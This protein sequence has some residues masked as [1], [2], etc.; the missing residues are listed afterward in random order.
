MSNMQ[1][2]FVAANPKQSF[3]RWM[4]QL[5][6]KK[7]SSVHL[8]TVPWV[9][10]LFFSLTRG[11]YKQRVLWR[12]SKGYLDLALFWILFHCGEMLQHWCMTVQLATQFCYQTEEL[13]PH[14]NFIFNPNNVSNHQLTRKGRYVLAF[15]HQFCTLQNKRL[16][17]SVIGNLK[18]W[19]NMY[20]WNHI[21]Q[22]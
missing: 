16:K 5:S 3:F 7:T 22:K 13:A 6:L 20:K 11:H 12:Y 1:I 4:L 2:F 14:H 8:S 15:M 10:P 19:S 17:S 21:R 18:K 9:L